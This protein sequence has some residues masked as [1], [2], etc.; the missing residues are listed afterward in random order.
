M[1]K[2]LIKGQFLRMSYI[3]DTNKIPHNAI[4]VPKN[5]E[6]NQFSLESIMEQKTNESINRKGFVEV[7]CAFCLKHEHFI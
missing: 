5:R 1:N 6:R 4:S 7:P 3:N 2:K